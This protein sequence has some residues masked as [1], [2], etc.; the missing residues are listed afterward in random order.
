[1]GLAYDTYGTP[2]ASPVV[3]LHALG[4]TRSDWIALADRLAN[5]GEVL[6]L[7]LRGHGDSDWP[8]IYS[9]AVMADDVAGLL[10]HIGLV[11][12]TL[13]GH[14]LGGVVAYRLAVGRPDLVGRLVVEDVC[15]PFA[16]DRALPERPDAVLPFDWEA[17]VALRGE[18]ERDDPD[19]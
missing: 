13:V 9:T 7:D 16:R 17:A 3:L 11:G 6:P 14:S 5:E 10:D 19:L 18:A 12:V 2:G 15:P 8:G 4:E 1:M